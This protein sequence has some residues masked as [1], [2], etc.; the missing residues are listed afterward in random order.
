[1]AER[2]YQSELI[3]K[4]KKRFPGCMVIKNNPNYIQGIPDL[5]VLYYGVWAALEV[6]ASLDAPSRPNQAR[7]VKRMNEMSFASF[8]CPET[9]KDVLN[10]L[11]QTFAS[12]GEARVS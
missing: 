1:M 6:K 11:Q 7:Y 2:H 8:I 5:L 3:K 10:A 9:E 12:V 4:L